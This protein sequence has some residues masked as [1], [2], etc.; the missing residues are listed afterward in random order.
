M[1]YELADCYAN[2]VSARAIS[3]GL[4]SW[5]ISVIVSIG[6]VLD[7]VYCGTASSN[8][9]MKR[10]AIQMGMAEEGRRRKHLFLNRKWGDVIE[11][12]V[13]RDEFKGEVSGTR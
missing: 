10:L 4:P 5:R 9:G 13:L 11:Y 8:V 12:G 2:V 7:H 3:A 1:S 6:S